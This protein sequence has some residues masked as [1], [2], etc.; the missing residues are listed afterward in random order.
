MFEG[1]QLNNEEQGFA[2]K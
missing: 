2:L 1:E